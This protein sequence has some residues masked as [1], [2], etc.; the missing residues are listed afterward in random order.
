[1]QL[2]L[3]LSILFR[4]KDVYTCTNVS[5]KVIVKDSCVHPTFIVDE[6]S[7]SAHMNKQI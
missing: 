5:Y 4:D 2:E 3:L 6:A 7:G 1:M